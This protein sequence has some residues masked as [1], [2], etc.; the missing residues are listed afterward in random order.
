MAKVTGLAHQIAV[1]GYDL[2][3]DISAIERAAVTRSSHPNQGINSSAIARQLLLAD[4]ALAFSTWFNDSALQEHAA[5]LASGAVPT[6]DR[7]AL[8][9]LGASVGDPAFMIS[10]KQVDY[11][12]SRGSDGALAIAVEIQGSIGAAPAWGVSLTAGWI[13]T[14][15]GGANASIDGGASSS[16]GA[17]AMIQHESIAGG[18]ADPLV[19]DST[20]D[21]S[22]GTLIAFTDV[23]SSPGAE[24]K[25]VSGTVERYVRGDVNDGG[26]LSNFK[27]C[28]AFRRG[29]ASEETAYS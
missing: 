27:Y 16:A 6:T 7:L 15:S 18:T 3:G 24:R 21:S 10:G 13:T 9:M 28:M 17:E 25:T 23:T 8:Y 29:T 11:A 19:E 14:S 1:A 5:L 4:G 22:F 20:N 2:S 12:P 26:S